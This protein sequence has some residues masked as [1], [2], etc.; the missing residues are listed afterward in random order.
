MPYLAA[1]VVAFGILYMLARAYTSIDPR[2]LVRG[3]R[4][5]V[6]GALIAF[7]LL[8]IVAE[9]WALGVLLAGAG[10]SAI[11]TGRIGPINLGGSRR[12]AGSAST[13]RSEW[14]E[15]QLDHDTGAMTGRVLK[16]SHAGAALGDLSD[17]VVKALAADVTADSESAALLEAYLDR[18][19]PGWRDHVEDDSA[20]GPRRT[21]NASAMADEEAYEILGL[22][23]GATQAE[24]R[25]A[26]RRLMKRVHPDQGGSTFLAAKINQAK[27][28]LLGKHR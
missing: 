11:M 10:V 19:M 14:F 7:G 8:L 13:V 9:R 25:A 20:A 6:G 28:R 15:M 12:S 23:P 22:L 5:G 18:R 1:G 17:D 4:F 16:G 3:L 2:R 27:D 24:I 21:P 26:H